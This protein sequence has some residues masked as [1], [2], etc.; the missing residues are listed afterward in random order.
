MV[1]T[2][3]V[4][5]PD[6]GRDY[7]FTYESSGSDGEAQIQISGQAAQEPIET[8]PKFNGEDGGS[9]VS[10]VDLAAIR[11]ALSS[12]DAPQFEGEG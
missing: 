1:S 12:G 9:T 11:A 6:G 7:I 8:H 5:R 3:Y 2:E 10:D 4:S